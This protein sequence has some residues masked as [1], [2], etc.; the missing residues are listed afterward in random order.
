MNDELKQSSQIESSQDA[1]VVGILKAVSDA[2]VVVAIAPDGSIRELQ[3]GDPIYVGEMVEL[4]SSGTALIE[5]SDGVLHQL[6]S[7]EAVRANPATLAALPEYEGGNALFEELLA[8]IESG[9][10][11]TEQLESPAAGDTGDGPASDEICQGALFSRTITEVNPQAG[12]DPDIAF[13]SPIAPTADTDI[14][15][16]VG[17][18]TGNPE[19]IEV[20]P[21][22]EAN[23][24]VE[25]GTEF[26]G[27]VTDN[28]DFGEVGPGTPKVVAVEGDANNIGE[29]ITG[30]FGGTIVINDDGS[31][32]YTPPDNVD[33]SNGDPTEVFEY[34]IQDANGTTAT[35]TISIVISDTS[36]TANDDGSQ[37]INEGTAISG[38]LLDNDVEGADAASVTHVNGNLLVFNGSGEAE[39]VTSKGTLIIN[40]AGEYTY[41]AN[42]NTG[43]TDSF[44]Y[45]LTDADGDADTADFSFQI[46]DV[47]S[48]VADPA[49]GGIDEDDLA[50]GSDSGPDGNSTSGSVSYSGIDTPLS[51]VLESNTGAY[52]TIVMDASGNWTYTLSGSATHPTAEGE[53]TL[54]DTFTYTVTDSD[55]ST[56]SNT[57][58]ITIVDDIPSAN[59]DIGVSTEQGTTTVI[60]VNGVLG[61][62]TLGA[63]GANATGVK[64]GAGSGESN[65]GIGIG[66]TG[67]YGTLTLAADGSYSYIANA[68]VDAGSTDSFTYTITD[69]D[70]DPSTATLTITFTG[71]INVPAA[72]SDS[73][74]IDED[75]LMTTTRR[76]RSCSSAASA[77]VAW[78]MSAALWNRG[79]PPSAVMI[80]A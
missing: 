43:G 17:E 8:S 76:P 23:P 48:P 50:G 54:T 19:F 68:S 21:S 35:T 36:P 41:T 45:T 29:S 20:V 15:E 60:D 12:F 5:T 77:S 53:N 33:N 61:N 37:N 70:G 74:S 7:G 52:G 25:S 13:P 73:G 62:D 27:N 14:I 28:D 69:A 31:Y 75:D 4:T 51:V 65:T 79:M 39:V 30:D 6:A 47:N 67:T 64:A 71:D 26:D 66:V 72:A 57:I 9:A 63:D 80:A 59:D 49:S 42:N 55:G 58:V 32:V 78:G 10:D 38:S 40:A 2:G 22:P 11:I 3:I 46:L 16:N 44:N 18:P 24:V 34:T 1:G 56:D